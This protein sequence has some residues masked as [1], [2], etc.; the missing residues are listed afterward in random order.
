MVMSKYQKFGSFSERICLFCVKNRHLSDVCR[1][2]TMKCVAKTII[3]QKSD[4][5][6]A[7]NMK[8]RFILCKKSETREHYKNQDGGRFGICPSILE[9]IVGGRNY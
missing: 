1:Q 9:Q 7:E 3:G 4:V 5:V 8:K 2:L 6:R